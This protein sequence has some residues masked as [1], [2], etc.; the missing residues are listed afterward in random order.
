[1]AE[2]RPLVILDN[3]DYSE[4]PSGDTLPAEAADAECYYIENDALQ[5]TTSTS[6]VTALTLSVPAIIGGKYKLDWSME[7]RLGNATTSDFR[8]Q[9]YAVTG[10]LVLA[11]LRISW[12]SLAGNL[13]YH[14]GAGMKVLTLGAGVAGDVLFR[15]RDIAGG[16]VG[17]RRSRMLFMRVAV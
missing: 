10:G 11:N 5:T 3:G 1:M 16:G 14:P 13:D 15:Y 6:W 7:Y 12:Q 9:V 2:R 17:L 4:L 8:F